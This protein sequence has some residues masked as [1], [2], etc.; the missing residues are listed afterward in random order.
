MTLDSCMLIDFAANLVN[1][2]GMVFGRPLFWFSS[3][4]RVP[5]ALAVA[6]KATVFPH[7]VSDGFY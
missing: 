2:A 4:G 6:G 5:N 3:F 1:F 7:D